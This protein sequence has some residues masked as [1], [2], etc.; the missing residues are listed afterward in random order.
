MDA[1]INEVTVAAAAMG[2]TSFAKTKL[3][4]IEQHGLSWFAALLAGPVA[5]LALWYFNKS[6]MPVEDVVRLGVTVS[7][8][9]NGIFDGTRAIKERVS[10]VTGY[11]RRGRTSEVPVAADDVAADD[12]A[13]TLTLPPTVA[14]AAPRGNG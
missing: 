1:G 10:A 4:W 12:T 5:A 9:T 8:A 13:I 6:T 3:P 14:E 2:L 7:L 11:V